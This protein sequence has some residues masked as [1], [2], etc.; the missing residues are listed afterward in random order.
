[1]PIVT[2]ETTQGEGKPLPSA[3]LNLYIFYG[4]GVI[5][6]KAKNKA[7]CRFE[8][9]K[10]LTNDIRIISILVKRRFK[11]KTKKPIAKEILNKSYKA[12]KNEI[13]RNEYQVKADD[14]KL[15]EQKFDRKKLNNLRVSE[16]KAL[17][18]A[19]KLRFTQITP[20]QEMVNL[21]LGARR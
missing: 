18:K 8:D 20:K 9:G 17:M 16:L 7:L 21:L 3:K 13:K 19:K 10:L 6:D 15:N 14:K 1:M 12:Y 2:K 5:W 11:Y 4:N